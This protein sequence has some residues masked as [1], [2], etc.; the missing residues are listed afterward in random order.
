MREKRYGNREGMKQKGTEGQQELII[1]LYSHTQQ[2]FSPKIY[3]L[4]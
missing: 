2:N 1:A 3:T 4:P